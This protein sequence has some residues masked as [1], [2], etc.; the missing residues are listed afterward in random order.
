MS[1]DPIYLLVVAALAATGMVAGLLAGLLGVGGGI[2]IVPVFFWGL[3]TAGLIPDI[4]SHLAVGTSLATI[5][6]TSISSMRAHNRKGNVAVVLLKRWGVTIFIGAALGGIA[7]RFIPGDA[8]R[9][10]F[11]VVALLVAVNMALPKQFTVAA[12]PPRKKWI[13]GAISSVVGFISSLMGIGGGTLSV[14]ILTA[15]NTP[16]HKAVGT[17]SAL[18]LLIAIPGMGGFMWAGWGHPDLPPFSLGYV[19]LPAVLIIAPFSYL[20]APIGARIAHALNPRPLKI[21][22]AVFLAITSL[23]MLLG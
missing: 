13:N 1:F 19:S 5:I 14:P 22:F 21:T 12:A 17:A 6:P 2:V 20:F 23:R 8:L 7:A 9:T 3:G 4:A 18:G 10:I 16:V 15:F 11:G